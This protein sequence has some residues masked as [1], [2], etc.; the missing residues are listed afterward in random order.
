MISEVHAIE[1][2]R[3]AIVENPAITPSGRVIVPAVMAIPIRVAHQQR[4]VIE[5]RSFMV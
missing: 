5:S 2:R 3:A 4:T 1:I